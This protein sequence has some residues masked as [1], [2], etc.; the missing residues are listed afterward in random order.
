MTFVLSPKM[1]YGI[2]KK[3]VQAWVAQGRPCR[4]VIPTFVAAS[5]VMRVWLWERDVNISLIISFAWLSHETR[6]FLVPLACSRLHQR[7]TPRF[8]TDRD[9]QTTT[10]ASSPVMPCPRDCLPRSLPGSAV[11]KASPALGKHRHTRTNTTLHRPDPRPDLQL[12]RRPIPPQR[13]LGP[14]HQ[15]L[16]PR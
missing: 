1:S 16:Q 6:L 5:C 11:T 7:H 12:R 13:L 2:G 3:D 15:P 10:F 4:S 9:V 14:H 8:H